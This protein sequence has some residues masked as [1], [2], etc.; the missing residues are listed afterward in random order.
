MDYSLLMHGNYVC[1]SEMWDRVGSRVQLQQNGTMVGIAGILIREYS[2]YARLECMEP[3][4]EEDDFA[5][6]QLKLRIMELHPRPRKFHEN[7]CMLSGQTEH[8]VV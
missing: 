4:G 7:H 5:M 6:M 3:A 8:H 1:T 2:S